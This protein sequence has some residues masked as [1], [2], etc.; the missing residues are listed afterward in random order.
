M[1]YNFKCE[2]C[3]HL[4]EVEMT[5]E[6]YRSARGEG[7]SCSLCSGVSLPSF[8]SDS[9]KV[10]FTGFD[11]SD[12]N[13]KE[14]EYRNG[15]SSFLKTKQKEVHHVPTLVP[16]FKGEKV[17]SWRE[18]REMAKKE[19]KIDFTYDTLVKKETSNKG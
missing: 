12:K 1:K 9:V 14:K 18:A 3:E 13:F 17:G 5:V 8:N 4:D 6:D 2:K 10:C 16:N 19:G 11:W 15:R 7:V